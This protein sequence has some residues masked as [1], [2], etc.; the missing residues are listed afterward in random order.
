MGREL[1]ARP[2]RTE[3]ETSAEAGDLFLKPG[4]LETREHIGE[5]VGHKFVARD[6][7]RG[8]RFVPGERQGKRQRYEG[9]EIRLPEWVEAVVGENILET[10]PK[11]VRIWSRPWGHVRGAVEAGEFVDTG[12]SVII[13]RFQLGRRFGL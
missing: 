12:S 8:S 1:G 5:N 2:L 13:E 11:V 6:R 7:G 3:R 10:S 4:A 9:Q